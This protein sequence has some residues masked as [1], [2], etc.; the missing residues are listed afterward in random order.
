M[1]KSNNPPSTL[2]KKRDVQKKKEAKVMVDSPENPSTKTDFQEEWTRKTVYIREEHEKKLQAMAFWGETP[3][4]C[5]LEKILDKF[6]EGKDIQPVP[7]TG[8]DKILKFFE[9]VSKQDS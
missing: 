2:S 3:L 8:K 1:S 9:K 6:F 4:K 7:K 5:V